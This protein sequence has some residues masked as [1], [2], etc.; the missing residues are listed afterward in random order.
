[1]TEMQLKLEQ[2]VT[3]L[4]RAERSLIREFSVGG[5]FLM[6]AS[7]AK[8]HAMHGQVINALDA[9]SKIDDCKAADDVNEAELL[10]R[11]VEATNEA[12]EIRKAKEAA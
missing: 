6:L 2:A 9:I 10:L 3:A 1:M 5:I 12:N 8:A 7:A 4:E 11:S